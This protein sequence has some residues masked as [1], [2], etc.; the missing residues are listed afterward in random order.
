MSLLLWSI[1]SSIKYNFPVIF[2]LL[3]LLSMFMPGTQVFYMLYYKCNI[4]FIVPS[5]VHYHV[6]FQFIFLPVWHFAMH[7]VNGVFWWTNFLKFWNSIYLLLLFLFFFVCDSA[8]C[9][10]RKFCLFLDYKQNITSVLF[11]KLMVLTLHWIHRPVF[12]GKYE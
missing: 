2:L 3:F 12:V 8:F 7:F 5:H 6:K 11:S 10:L 4:I 1:E 9:V